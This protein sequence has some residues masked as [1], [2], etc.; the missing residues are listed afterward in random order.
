MSAPKDED[1]GIQMMSDDF[2]PFGL[3]LTTGVDTSIIDIELN[4]QQE[5]DSNI[6]LDNSNS[7][8]VSTVPSFSRMIKS[9]FSTSS[10]S[11]PTMSL[12]PKLTVKLA[13]HE[14]ASSIAIA[15]TEGSSEVSVEGQ[16][17]A[18]VQCSDAKRN[19]P[20]RF[21]PEGQNELFKFQPN[22][23]FGIEAEDSNVSSV[24][25]VHIPKHE[26]GFVQ[27]GS[28]SLSNVVQHMPILLERRVTVKGTSCRVAIQVRSKLSN[29]GDINDFT[30][31]LAVPEYVSGDPPVTMQGDG[32]WDQLK[33]VSFYLFFFPCC[34]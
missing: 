20:F 16:I 1:D 6:A 12:P 23:A 11:V 3:N 31:A 28:F 34:F 17:S 4:K 19:V 13:I 27:I 26:I 33:R 14:E 5:S 30:I 22:L 7:V 32:T 25:V 9:S 29:K 18:Q 21:E 8:A 10:R 15:N 24:N 2:D